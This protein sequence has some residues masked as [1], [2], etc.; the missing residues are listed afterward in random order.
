MRAW[1]YLVSA[2]QY[3]YGVSTLQALP[4]IYGIGL[5]SGSLGWAMLKT[6]QKRSLSISVAAKAQTKTRIVDRMYIHQ[7]TEEQIG[8][9]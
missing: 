1:P 6:S 8:V 5:F 9:C 3:L 2:Y 7:D 4:L